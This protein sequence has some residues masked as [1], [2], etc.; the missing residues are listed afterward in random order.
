MT[1]FL[2]TAAILL[3]SGTAGAQ[4]GEL[5]QKGASFSAPEQKGAT[6]VADDDAAPRP[7]DG[8]NWGATLK[9]KAFWGNQSYRM[10][11]TYLDVAAPGGLDFSA[12]FNDYSNATSS[13]SPTITF[14]AGWTAGQVAYTGTYAI[15]TLANDYEATALDV[16]IS[17]KTDSQ[18]FR[19]LFA[20]DVNS[21]KHRNFLYFPKFSDEQD[22][23]Q[24]SPTGSISQRLYGNLDAK[25]TVSE[26]T[27]NRNILAYTTGLS[28][29]KTK[30]QRAFSS[31]AGSL[32]G[33][34]DGFPD[35]SLKFGL[36]YDVDPVPLTLRA[37]YQ[38]IRLEDTAQGTNTTADVSTYAAD[39]DVRKWATISF[40]YDH[41][42]QTSQV[43]TDNYGLIAELRY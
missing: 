23:T 41:T 12:D 5:F 10:S 6:P 36:T 34:I 43:T 32:T 42:R 38:Y 28:R 37:T 11:D 35:W 30:G 17:V 40:E 7:E 8:G 22:L 20:A 16:G 2:L 21:T 13:A 18:D 33:L 26:S 25:A 24:V 9:Q 29:N 14:G 15:T 39:Y 1:A 27:Y 31:E 4:T 3:G 19:T